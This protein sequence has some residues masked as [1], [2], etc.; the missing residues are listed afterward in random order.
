MSN[1]ITLNDPKTI[2]IIK[3]MRNLSSPDDQIFFKAYSWIFNSTFFDEDGLD[4]FCDATNV[5][6]FGVIQKIE[7]DNPAVHIRFAGVLKKMD[8]ASRQL[9]YFA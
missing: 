8:M 5:S 7:S 4:S 1:V 9:N 3:T 2:Y 6:M